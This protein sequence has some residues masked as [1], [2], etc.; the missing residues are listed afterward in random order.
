M[1]KLLIKQHRRNRSF[2]AKH[3]EDSSQMQKTWYQQDICL[4]CSKYSHKVSSDL[5]A[6]LNLDISNICKS[7]RFH[8]IDN[9]SISMNFLHLSYSGKELLAKKNYF[10]INNFL[11]KHTYH[12]KIHL[13]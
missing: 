10:N 2:I 7:N 1:N 8:F 4:K 13:N 12:P 6:K 11:R 3:L 9:S 5:I